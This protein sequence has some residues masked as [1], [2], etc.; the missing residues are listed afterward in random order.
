MTG[1]A[2]LS[3]AKLLAPEACLVEAPAFALMKTA[4]IMRENTTFR[5]LLTNCSIRFGMD[6]ATIKR[7]GRLSRGCARC[8]AVHAFQT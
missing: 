2:F 3:G 1:D 5:D 4:L 8:L 7:Q 6:N